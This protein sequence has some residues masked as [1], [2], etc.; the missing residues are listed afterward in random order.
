MGAATQPWNP[1]VVFHPLTPGEFMRFNEP[2]YVKIVWTLRADPVG[3]Q[4]CIFRHETRVTTTDRVARAKFRRYWAQF[5]PGI[6]LIRWLLL[7]QVRAEAER[8]APRN[9]NQALPTAVQPQDSVQMGQ[10]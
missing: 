9:H 7:P 3:E 2:N 8:R 5:S 10:S 4:A 1:N 6:K